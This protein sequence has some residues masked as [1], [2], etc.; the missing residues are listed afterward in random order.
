M[1]RPILL[2]LLNMLLL[3]AWNSAIADGVVPRNVSKSYVAGAQGQ[4]AFGS[5]VG[6]AA[7]NFLQSYYPQQVCIDTGPPGPVP[8]LSATGVIAPVP[9]QPAHCGAGYTAPDTSLWT[10]DVLSAK[11]PTWG[12]GIVKLRDFSVL[13]IDAGCPYN[14]TDLPDGSCRCNAG[15]APAQVGSDPVCLPRIDNDMTS[16]GSGSCKA[17]PRVGDPIFPLT[18]VEKFS[19]DL[20]FLVGGIPLKL[21]YDTMRRAPVDTPDLELPSR[22]PSAFRE[23]W[24][25]SLHRQL[26]IEVMG[27]VIRAFRGNGE[28]VTFLKDAAGR[29]SSGSNRSVRLDVVVGGY[30]ITDRREGVIEQYDPSGLWTSAHMAD[31]R[32]VVLRYSDATTPVSVAPGMGHLV[33]A[34]DGFGREIVFHYGPP[35]TGEASGPVKRISGQG[36]TIFIDQDFGVLR[37]IEWPDGRMRHYWYDHPMHPWALTSIWDEDRNLYAQIQY[38]DKGR[39][40]SSSLGGGTDTYSVTYTVPPLVSVTDVLDASR[41]AVIRTRAWAAPQGVAVTQPNGSTRV[42]QSAVVNGMNVMTTQSQPAGS[43]CAAA[44][45]AQTY[46]TSGNL[47]S[48]DNFN[49][50]RVCY[51]HDPVRN[52]ETTRVEG[53]TATS[54]SCAAASQGPLPIGARKISSRWHPQWDLRVLQAEPGRLTGFIYNGQPDWYA[55]GNTASCVEAGAPSLPD[56]TPLALL[57]RQVEEATSDIDGSQGFTPTL[58]TGVPRREHRWTYNKDGQVLTHDGPRTDVADVTSFE[59]YAATQFSGADPHASGHT[60]GDLKRVTNPAGHITTF[61]TYN[62]SGQVLESTD[63]RGVATSSTYDQRGRLIAQAVAGLVTNYE[64]WPTGLLRRATQHDGSYFDYSYDAAHR[65]V[66]IRNHRGDSTSYVLDSQGN[67]TGMTITDPN[68]IL[69]A[70]LS[71]SFDALNR[72]QQVIGRDLDSP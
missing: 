40:I 9:R 4:C 51:A 23:P 56:G 69:R 50:D 60:R 16:S 44:S 54:A 62:K 38:D 20:G 31:G 36:R 33:A 57:C 18:G 8:F 59:Y 32:T 65:L 43:G 29:Y 61:T 1:N 11:C 55:G 63:S 68:G 34:E 72:V 37:N 12:S 52:I 2:V 28:V 27:T 6:E 42:M 13:K 17:T 7:N 48:A 70:T 53:L 66:G 22:G 5:T 64:Y 14:S 58:H 19:V 25:G 71:R 30:R 46:D 10:Y 15:Y 67:R 39:A 45:S 3:S 49:G 35:I 47:A 41:T 26:S 24:H 21:T